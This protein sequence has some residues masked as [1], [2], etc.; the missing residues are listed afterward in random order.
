MSKLHA[1]SISMLPKVWVCSSLDIVLEQTTDTKHYL[2]TV[3][4]K[5]RS[6]FTNT[7][8][9]INRVK[10]ATVLFKC[11]C[12]LGSFSNW[13]II[14]LLQ[15]VLCCW[16]SHFYSSIICSIAVQQLVLEDKKHIFP[17][18]CISGRKKKNFQQPW[19]RHTLKILLFI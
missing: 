13:K 4:L 2:F 11:K 5:L 8:H 17:T 7:G 19:G 9:N 12:N 16:L 15:K 3:H 14:K 18:I 6:T 10:A 1:W